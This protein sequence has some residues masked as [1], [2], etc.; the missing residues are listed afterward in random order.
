VKEVFA[1]ANSL[2]KIFIFSLPSREIFE[3]RDGCSDAE[4]IVYCQFAFCCHPSH[5]KYNCSST[6]RP[7]IS[8][9]Y[10]VIVESVG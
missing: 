6:A 2:P 1:L 4:E 8:S 9:L 10:Q 7:S 5:L 3:Y